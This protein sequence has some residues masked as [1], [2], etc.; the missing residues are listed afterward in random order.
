MVVQVPHHSRHHP[1]FPPDIALPPCTYS[2]TAYPSSIS[3]STSCRPLFVNEPGVCHFVYHQSAHTAGV[4]TG[5][6]FQNNQIQPATYAASLSKGVP[7]CYGSS[8][9]IMVSLYLA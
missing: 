8:V 9:G 1:R 3:T 4:G 2:T 6:S 5:L 7:A